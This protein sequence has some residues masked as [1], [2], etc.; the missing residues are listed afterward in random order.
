M[1]RARARRCEG[2]GICR[3]DLRYR[4]ISRH[5]WTTAMG[6]SNDGRFSADDSDWVVGLLHNTENGGI[7]MTSKEQNYSRVP[8]AEN[9]LMLPPERAG[10]PQQFTVLEALQLA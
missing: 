9:F 10:M 8:G 4:R 1:K 5:S 6:H 3:L 2:N 7:R